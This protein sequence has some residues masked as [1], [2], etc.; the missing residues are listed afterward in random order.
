MVGEN[1]SQANEYLVRKPFSPRPIVVV[2]QLRVVIFR[3]SICPQKFF[4]PTRQ[5]GVLLT[6]QCP[7]HPYFDFGSHFYPSVSQSTATGH[8]GCDCTAGPVISGCVV[9]TIRPGNPLKCG[10]PCS[11][12]RYSSSSEHKTASLEMKAP[13]RFAGH[14]TPDTTNHEAPECVLLS[15][16]FE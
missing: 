8:A 15:Y 9:F 10:T 11:W 7:R 6:E 13:A 4:D 2:A 14:G 16:C 3:G 12:S 5:P 1:L